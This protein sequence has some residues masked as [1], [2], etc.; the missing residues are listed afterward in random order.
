[1]YFPL[2]GGTVKGVSKAGEIVWSRVYIEVS[3]FSVFHPL[4]ARM[5]N[6]MLILEEEQLLSYQILKLR[7]DGKQLH[8]N[9]QL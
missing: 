6:S 8:M 4:I 3:L 7:E 5:E 2:G 1:M 9:G